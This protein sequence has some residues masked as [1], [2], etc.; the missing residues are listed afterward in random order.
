[1]VAYLNWLSTGLPQHA[2]IEGASVDKVDTNLAPEPVHGK[3]VYEEKCA[4]CHGTNGQG[5]ENARNELVIPPLWEINLSTSA[6]AWPEP[7]LP[8]ALSRITCRWAKRAFRI[9]KR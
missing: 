3:A 8:P 9:R 7:I 4:R 2:K 1:M 5:L 6:Q